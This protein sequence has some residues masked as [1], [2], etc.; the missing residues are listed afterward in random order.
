MIKQ[1]AITEERFVSRS[2]EKRIRTLRGDPNPLEPRA[3]VDRG[4]PD[5]R[6]KF[7]ALEKE[8]IRRILSREESGK[9]WT[10]VSIFVENNISPLIREF[11][12]YRAGSA[13]H[14]TQDKEE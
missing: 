9:K 12:A 8:I 14:V 6:E 2:Q 10:T 13:S 3:S 1:N 7:E 5:E 11:V 4:A